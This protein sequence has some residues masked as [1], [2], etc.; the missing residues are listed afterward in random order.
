[1]NS[2]SDDEDVLNFWLGTLDENGQA[3]AA[4]TKSWFTKDPAFD[5]AIRDRFGAVHSAIVAGKLE[6]W[7]ELPRGCLA[8]V[9][10]LD[11]FSRNMFRDSARMFAQDGQALKAAEAAVERG[12]D[13]PMAFDE[14]GFVYMPF[15]HSEDLAAQDRGVALFSAFRDELQG[16]PRERI[17][18]SLGYANGHRDIIKRFGRFPHRNALLGRPST[19]EETEFLTQPGSSF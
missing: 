6:G 9:I 10:V 15:M 16:K 17:E 7:L 19:P 12:W 14:R 3:D 11:Q 8:Y 2:A 4:H 1:M 5:Q 18:M 13:K